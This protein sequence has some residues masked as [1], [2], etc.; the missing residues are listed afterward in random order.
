MRLNIFLLFLHFS[1]RKEE[2]AEEEEEEKIVS[3]LGLNSIFCSPPGSFDPTAKSH[4]QDNAQSRFLQF[5]QRGGEQGSEG[6]PPGGQ[7]PPPQNSSRRS[8][9]QDKQLGA[10][11]EIHDE[12]I[13]RIPSP[14]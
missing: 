7:Q 6:D 2:E 14:V 3:L 4:V 12:P 5:F 11:R 10:N 1:R 13:T 8:S 9:I